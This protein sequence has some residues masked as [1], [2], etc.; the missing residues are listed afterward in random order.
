M[1]EKLELTING[2]PVE[3]KLLFD[4]PLENDHP[5]WGKSYGFKVSVL[6][7][8]QDARPGDER[9]IFLNE[10][11]PAS[12]IL[13]ALGKDQVFT[14]SKKQAAG[15]QYA[16]YIVETPE[17]QAPNGPAPAPTKTSEPVA[18][19]ASAPVVTLIP[20][21]FDPVAALAKATDGAYKAAEQ[22]VKI[23]TAEGAAEEEVR[24]LVESAAWL[25]TATDKLYDYLLAKA[26]Q[27]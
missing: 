13:L 1:T 16:N 21:G 9:I 26:R 22:T 24:D 3:A 12:R 10:K 7:E 18:Q 14:I 23:M 11:S 17:G 15:D 6:N 19:G 20:A 5:K 27:S 25:A 4:R 8:S 2:S